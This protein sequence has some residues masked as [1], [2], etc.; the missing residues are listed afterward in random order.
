MPEPYT[1]TEHEQSMIQRTERIATALEK[2]ANIAREDLDF[3]KEQLAN[4]AAEQKELVA[5]L[6]AGVIPGGQATP[7]LEHGR[8]LRRGGS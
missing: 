4:A 2:I 1:L 7:E 3:R 8:R 5:R 6:T